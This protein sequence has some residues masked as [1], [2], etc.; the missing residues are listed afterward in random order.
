MTFYM[1]MCACHDMLELHEAVD[2]V[3][4]SRNP[5]DVISHIYLYPK[6]KIIYA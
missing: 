1:H 6:N 5:Q 2:V 3:L 4:G